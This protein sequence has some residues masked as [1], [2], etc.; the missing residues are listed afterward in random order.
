MKSKKYNEKECH[1]YWTNLNTKDVEKPLTIAQLY[2]WFKEDNLSAFKE[3]RLFIKTCI[4]D[5]CDIDIADV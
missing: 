5:C 2:A 4:A 3:Y 1:A